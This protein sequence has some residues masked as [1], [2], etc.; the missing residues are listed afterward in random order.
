MKDFSIKNKFC[1]HYKYLRENVEVFASFNID[2]CPSILNEK[3]TIS[4]YYN[5]KLD[6]KNEMSILD[7]FAAKCKLNKR[8]WQIPCEI[9]TYVSHFHYGSVF[10]NREFAYVTTFEYRRP[11]YETL[12]C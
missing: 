1:Q 11:I 7:K 9:A 10:F 2:R 6:V 12:L 4:L 3:I 5:D 8:G